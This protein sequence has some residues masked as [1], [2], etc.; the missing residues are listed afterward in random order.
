MTAKILFL[1]EIELSVQAREHLERMGSIATAVNPSQ[2]ALS[3]MVSDAIALIFQLS[4][5]HITSWVMDAAP[6]LKVIGR[7]GIG[8]EQIDISAARARDIAVVN[9]A[10]AQASAVAD[11]ALGLMLCLARKIVQGDTALRS[12]QWPTPASLVGHDLTQK[13]LG[14]IGFGAIGRA[15]ASRVR[16]FDM[17]VLAFDPYISPERIAALGGAPSDLPTLLASSDYISIHVPLTSETTKLIGREEL[18][19]V[20]PDAYVINTSRGSVVDEAGL[21]EMLQH[22]EI[23]GAGLD[24]F[25]NEPLASDSPLLQMN[26]VVLTPH[27]G[28]WTV[29]AQAK[30]RE[31][32][33]EDVAR[34]LGGL[35]PLRP[36]TA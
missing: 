6:N 20:S 25:E 32:V 28:G 14:V 2:V 13:T 31:M 15:L 8:T 36:V 10:G 12:G 33:A 23:A 35:D 5:L 11:H 30:T 26:N 18:R 29:E 34:V 4:P 1:D 17:S 9:A 19:Y 21:I 16:S 22:G 3:S 24:V 27:I 7:I